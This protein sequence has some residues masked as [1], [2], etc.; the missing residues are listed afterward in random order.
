MIILG[1]D[2]GLANMGFA[3]VEVTLLRA[4]LLTRGVVSTEKET[5]RRKLHQGSDDARRIDELSEAIFEW[6]RAAETAAIVRDLRVCIAYEMPSGAQNARAAHALGIA[7]GLTR[8][9]V[10][11]HIDRHFVPVIDVTAR[12]AKLALTGRA[13]ATKEQCIAAAARIEGGDAVLSV[14]KGKREHVADAIGVALAA[15]R[16]PQV[17]RALEFGGP[18][19]LEPG[20]ER[21]GT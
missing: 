7:H 16:S 18:G 2:P 11:A 9:S 3:I 20:H 13:S 4:R 21:L 17:R 6:I 5:A 14:S 8:A 12:D 10:I 15:A 19:S 1:I